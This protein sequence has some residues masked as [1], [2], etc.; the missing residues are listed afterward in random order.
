MQHNPVCPK[1]KKKVNKYI[2]FRP[3]HQTLL[4][5]FPSRCIFCYPGRKW[6]TLNI[7]DCFADKTWNILSLGIKIISG[8]HFDFYSHLNSEQ[9]DS[10][11]LFVLNHLKC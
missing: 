7:L 6:V 11:P 1:K 10:D 2:K 8:V 5:P 4:H 3:Q 9:V